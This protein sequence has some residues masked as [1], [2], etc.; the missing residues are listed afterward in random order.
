MDWG[1]L[2]FGIV[3]LCAGIWFY[4]LAFGVRE[5][6]YVYSW[7]G[8]LKVRLMEF[9]EDDRIGLM[10]GTVILGSFAEA[11]SDH[12]WGWAALFLILG[13]RC[14][15]VAWR[16]IGK[17]TNPASLEYGHRYRPVRVLASILLVLLVI[18]LAGCAKPAEAPKAAT[19]ADASDTVY[20]GDLVEPESRGAQ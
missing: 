3:L 10:A 13:W 11:L 2:L 7:R 17:V 20:I 9:A 14:V 18:L 15:H 1:A 8:R 5:P 19:P 6:A 4:A 12:D 16:D